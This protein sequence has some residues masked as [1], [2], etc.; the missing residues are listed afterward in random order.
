MAKKHMK[1]SNKKLLLNA[2]PFGF[3]PAAA[4]ASFYPY[5]KKKFK[6]IGYVGKD[7]TLDLQKG[8]DYDSIHDISNLTKKDERKELKKVLAKYDILLTALDFE[9]AAQAKK[10]GLKVII[11]DPLAWYWKE[12]PKIVAKSDLYIAQ[13]FFGVRERLEKEKEKFP[14]TKIT[15]PITERKIKRKKGKYVLINLGGLQN[16]FLPNGDLVLYAKIMLKTIKSI[17]PKNE[18]IIIATSNAIAKNLKMEKVRSFARKEMLSILSETKLAFMTPGLGNIY[19]VA[20]FGIPTVWLPP[21]NDSQG[22]QAQYLSDNKM[23]DGLLSWDILS[24]KPINYIGEQEKVLKKIANIAKKSSKS[25]ELRKLL[26]EGC[27]KQYH[28]VKGENHNASRKLLK[29]F[30]KGGSEKV[31]RLIYENAK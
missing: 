28:N 23:A 15:P 30:G 2:E 7:H 14:K 24:K 3:G 9:I 16:P 12:I 18:K 1:K 27:N 4:I 25:K 11:Y 8:L 31:A 21:A 22:Q 5:L 29:K 6:T 19:D 26:K 13:D 17:L 10:L 20:R